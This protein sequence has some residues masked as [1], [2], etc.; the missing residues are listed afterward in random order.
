[1]EMRGDVMVRDMK[2]PEL[3]C[4][5]EEDFFI[6]FTQRDDRWSTQSFVF[7]PEG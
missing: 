6:W 4:C 1:M 5:R 3:S 2:E 7:G